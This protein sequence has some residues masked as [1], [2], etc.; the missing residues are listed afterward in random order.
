[1]KKFLLFIFLL[2]IVV[3]VVIF[4]IPSLRT[5]I[6]HP[7]MRSLAMSIVKDKV[8]SSGTE[9]PA[10]GNQPTSKSIVEP[11]IER[12]KADL[13]GRQIPGWSFD[14]ITEFRQASVTSIART[15]QRIDFRLDLR[16][17][18]FN[19]RD[20]EYYDIQ[21]FA[22]YL[23]GDDGWYPDRLEEIFIAFDV[24]ISPGKW[25]NVGSIAG[26]SLHPDTKN[27]LVWT[28]ASWDYEIISGPGA[29]DI[30]LPAAVNYQ[31]KVN[32]K[33]PI[34]ARLTFRPG[35]E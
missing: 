29:G 3:V 35:T 16:M 17:L 11:D 4:S 8:S 15:D 14:R 24:M 9:Y 5:I 22:I 18:P 19:A 26:C 30:A 34:K 7:Q 31:V 33:K 2:V 27:N 32:G 10:N 25:I 23:L 28:S 12:I 21:M 13:V 6:L 1:M 20:E